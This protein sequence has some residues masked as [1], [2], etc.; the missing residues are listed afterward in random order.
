MFFESIESAVPERSMLFKPGQ[1]VLQ[2]SGL[3]PAPVDTTF[4]LLPHEA[5]IPEYGDVLGDGLLRHVEGFDKLR[6]GGWAIYEPGYDFA[7]GRIRQCGECNILIHN[8]MVV[9]LP[10]GVMLVKRWW[11]WWWDLGRRPSTKCVA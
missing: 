1:R 8:H 6:N 9:N 2:R 7:P 10:P 3:Q 5:R 11:I 4:T